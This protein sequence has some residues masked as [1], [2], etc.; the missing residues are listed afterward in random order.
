MSAHNHRERAPGCF[1]CEM[2]S[3][4]IGLAMTD[5][6]VQHAMDYAR[7]GGLYSD[8]P[9]SREALTV[10]ANE[11]ERLREALRA[12][13]SAAARML[14]PICNE[15]DIAQA[16]LD[17][18]REGVRGLADDWDRAVTETLIENPRASRRQRSDL[19]VASDLVSD[20]RSILPG[21]EGGA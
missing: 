12:N 18:L 4:E 7:S 6:R 14:A 19:K 8:H 20:F 16:E 9:T 3:D 2:T 13:A 17:R 1:R 21:D 5:E 10:L 11:V 15:R